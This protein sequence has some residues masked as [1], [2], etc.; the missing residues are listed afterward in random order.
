[1]T[2]F[3]SLHKQLS[4]YL[5]EKDYVKAQQYVKNLSYPEFIGL[6]DLCDNYALRS[7]H[8]ARFLDTARQEEI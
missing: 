7:N 5:F 4:S 3:K 6:C 2:D 8:T 1:M